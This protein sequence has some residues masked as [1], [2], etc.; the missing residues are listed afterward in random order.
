M[1]LKWK[2]WVICTISV[3]LI[4]YKSSDVGR[5]QVHQKTRLTWSSEPRIMR[6]MVNGSEKVVSGGLNDLDIGLEWKFNSTLISMIRKDILRFLDAERDVSVIKSSFKPGD[7]IHYVLDRRRTFNVSQAL[8]SLI[9]EVSPLKNKSFKTCAVVGNSG[10]LLKSGC[11]K[12]I[13]NHSFV[14]R[15][16]LFADVGLRSDFTTMNP[17]VIQRVYGGLREE[18]QQ[19]SFIQRLQKLNNSTL[20]VPAFLVKGGMKYVDNVNKLILQHKLNVHMAYPSLRL[21]HAVRGY[22]LTNKIHIKRPSTGL[23][24]YTMA[25]RFCEQIYL[26]GFWPF[27]KDALGNPVKYH[28]FDGL[29]YRYFSSAGPHRMPLEFKTLQNLHRNGALKL[30]TSTCEGS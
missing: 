9:P 26:Y 20:W 14:I 21:I 4:F 29:K 18:D 12:E 1:Q 10:I 27:P 25:T 11:G 16:S 30:T 24:M 8:H 19:Q 28:Y 5:N 2:H 15:V 23:L 22:W 17:S 7:T 6:L 13:D 3:L